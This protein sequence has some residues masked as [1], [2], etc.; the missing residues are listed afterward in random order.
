MKKNV[1]GR[2]LPI[3][4]QLE[5]KCKSGPDIIQYVE[6]KL[7][8]KLE[9]G[10]QWS[11]FTLENEKIVIITEHSRMVHKISFTIPEIDAFKQTEWRIRNEIF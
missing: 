5:L 2:Y 10:F 1:L 9:V 4:P 8:R 7:H 6:Q 11:C 3:V